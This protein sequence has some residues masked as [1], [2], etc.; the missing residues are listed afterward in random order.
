[1][2]D[3]FSSVSQEYSPL[4]MANLPPNVQ[5]HLTTRPSDEIIPELS[6]Y[7]V[8]CRI[9]K[10]KKPNS[11]IPGD[12]SKKVVQHC[13]AQLAVPSSAIFNSITSSAVYP[14]QWKIEHQLPVPNV[15]PPLSEDDLHNIAKT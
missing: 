13:P 15:Y 7:D 12:L 2:T 9:V 11:S 14:E 5:S 1:M 3:Y 8:Y 6:V 4:D 10:A